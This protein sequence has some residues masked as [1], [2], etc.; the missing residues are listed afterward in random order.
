MSE[1]TERY[2][3]SIRLFGEEGQRRLRATKTAIIG[4]GGLG[5]AVAQHL[6]LLG[7]E[8]VALVDNEELDNTN[9]NRFIGARHTD[10]VPGS[11]KVDIAARMIGEINPDVEAIPLLCT[12]TSPEAFAA[13]RE[14]DWIFGCFDGD[15]PRHILNEVCAA[16]AKPYI[17]L[18]SD[19]PEA[20]IYGGRVFASWDGNGCLHCFGLLDSTDVRRFLVTEEERQ[21]EDAIYGVSRDALNQTGPSVSP[22]NGVVASL[23]VTEFMAA[24][25]GMREPRRLVNYRG[26][27]STVS[28]SRD[29]PKSNCPYCKGIWGKPEAAGIERY[30]EIPHLRTD[31]KA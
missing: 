13:I 15:G 3:R 29:T 21:R 27:L 2:N 31:M 7:V 8:R 30:L 14:A 10:P 23:A 28:A 1:S 11:K 26:H 19:V 25:T 4:V 16:H 17:D 24:A 12:L 20:G 22:V 18:A 5:S 9:R 6:A